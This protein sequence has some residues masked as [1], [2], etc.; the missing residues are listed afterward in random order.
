MAWDDFQG[1]KTPHS[2]RLQREYARA[3]ADQG[4][5]LIG[6]D[7][8][9]AGTPGGG[10]N[11]NAMVAAGYD[12][13]VFARQQ[14]TAGDNPIYSG[15]VSP[16]ISYEGQ[17]F[18]QFAKAAGLTPEQAEQ[19]FNQYIAQAGGVENVPLRTKIPIDALIGEYGASLPSGAAEWWNSQ[20][21]NEA[22]TQAQSWQDARMAHNKATG[23]WRQFAAPASVIA[24][25]VIGPLS[26][27]LGLTAAPAAATM[28]PAFADAGTAG[29]GVGAGASAGG[30]GNLVTGIARHVP[31]FAGAILG[32]SGGDTV[33]RAAAPQ[34]SVTQASAPQA[35][36]A[37]ESLSESV[38]SQTTN[39]PRISAP[40]S[41]SN[42]V[43]TTSAPRNVV[44]RPQ[45]RL[46]PGFR[47]GQ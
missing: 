13:A 6:H 10:I 36:A 15:L 20:G 25:M 43:M 29:L 19:K 26:A 4:N 18:G 41:L 31:R 32:D 2:A 14:G 30:L 1:F 35:P 45:I 42:S 22:E 8:M 33:P 17:M 23:G 16:E 40:Q 27:A 12:P 38:L 46:S 39:A 9:E 7:P 44:R 47:R 24:P 28:M 3:L 37:Q 11:Y 21:R 5:F 34:A